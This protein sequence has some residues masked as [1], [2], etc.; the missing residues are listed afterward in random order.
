MQYLG[1]FLSPTNSI[2]ED[3]DQLVKYFYFRPDKY[4]DP[5]A[6][7]ENI[8]IIKSMDQFP[9]RKDKLAEN[10][11]YAV[12]SIEVA[13][14]L[15]DEQSG[16]VN[17][18]YVVTATYDLLTNIQ[19]RENS[20]SSGGGSSSN[21]NENKVQLDE[22]GF[23]VTNQ[24]PPWKLRAKVSWQ[25]IAVNTAFT[26]AWQNGQKNK[27]VVNAAGN[28]LLAE[29]QRYQLEITYIKSFSAPDPYFDW[30][31]APLVNSSNIQ[32]SFIANNKVFAT[33][34]LLILP[35]SC[36]LDYFQQTDE[37]G[38]IKYTP[39]YTYTVK[40]IY[41]PED[42][43]KKVLNMGNRANFG[44][45]LRSETIYQLTVSN[46]NGTLVQ[47]PM[48]TNA[49]GVLQW[50]A[51]NKNNKYSVQAQ[52]VNQPLPLD[53]TGAIYTA[54]INDPITNPCHI[55]R[56]AQFNNLDFSLFH[57]VK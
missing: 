39:Y 9:K 51:R 5:E 19:K 43:D 41:D 44:G 45:N 29:T 4:D 15:G 53:L 17:V 47:Q 48:Y 55:L 26:K 18:S 24:T 33:K 10:E 13:K 52:I 46:Q 57:F 8:F 14:R 27:D 50:R 7:I 23:I 31:T 11:L 36:Q 40:M 16:V 12:E 21:Q 32:W 22:D 20:G 37:K 28:R 38:K 56:F 42:W 34:T 25:P 35:P 54:S 6:D 2:S 3:Q 49:S 1:E 30:I